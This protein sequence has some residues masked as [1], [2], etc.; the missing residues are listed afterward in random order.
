MRQASATPPP[1]LGVWG[2][3]MAGKGF[4]VRCGKSLLARKGIWSVARETRTLM[5]ARAR[6]DAR[7]QADRGTTSG[8]AG[9]GP[10][11]GPVPATLITRIA[12][13]TVQR[14]ED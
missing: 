8:A 10:N 12:T 14:N 7:C 1:L 6:E 2:W 5:R 9:G 3:G 11:D 13:D 4:K